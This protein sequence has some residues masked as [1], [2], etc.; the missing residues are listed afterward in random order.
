M[1]V[2]ALRG[3]YVFEFTYKK[4]LVLRERERMKAIL[5]CFAPAEGQVPV[6]IGDA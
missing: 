2:A 3:V 5:L 1:Y 4:V 6:F